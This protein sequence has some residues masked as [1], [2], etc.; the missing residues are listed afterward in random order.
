MRYFVLFVAK[1]STLM[2]G[3]GDRLRKQRQAIL[4]MTTDKIPNL[5][6]KKIFAALEPLNP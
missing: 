1:K 2:Q 6:H 3:V 5:K 4:L